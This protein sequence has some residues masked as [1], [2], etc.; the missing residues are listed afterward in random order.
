LGQ[1][2]QSSMLKP[3]LLR[4]F[5]LTFAGAWP[6]GQA[7]IRPSSDISNNTYADKL[8]GNTGLTWTAPD[9]SFATSA[10]WGAIE[11]MVVAV[12]KDFGGLT[13]RYREAPLGRGAITE[14]D[15]IKVTQWGKALLKAMAVIGG[16]EPVDRQAAPNLYIIYGR[17]EKNIP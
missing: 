15:E 14:L 12:L 6:C 3:T 4:F 8:I 2:L 17:K 11:R 9:S 1:L 16:Y 7:K 13:C 10:L 5:F